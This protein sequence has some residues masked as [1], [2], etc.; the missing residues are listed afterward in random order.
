MT[1]CRGQLEAESLELE[2]AV[3]AKEKQLSSL[4]TENRKT[5]V[6]SVALM[7]IL[8]F[9]YYIYITWS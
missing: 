4:R 7:L 5:M 8:L 9:F 1:T 6:V 2:A 3:E